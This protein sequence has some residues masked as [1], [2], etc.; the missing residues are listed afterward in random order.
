VTVKGKERAVEVG[1][2]S[3]KGGGGDQCQARPRKEVSIYKERGKVK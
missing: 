1:E 2:E 3:G